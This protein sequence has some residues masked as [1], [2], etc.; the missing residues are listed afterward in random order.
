MAWSGSPMAQMLPSGGAICLT[1]RTCCAST[2]WYSSI[3]THRQRCRYRARSSGMASSV[4]AARITRSSKSH[5]LR[6]SIALSYASS[7]AATSLGGLVSSRGASSRDAPRNRIAPRRV[8]PQRIVPST[9]RSVAHRSA[10]IVPQR[11]V[12]REMADSRLRARR[13]EMPSASRR[14]WT[15]S[16]SDATRKP[17]CK[18]AALWC[19]RR[20]DRPR[21]WNVC[22]GTRSQ[23]SGS[24][25]RRRS[26]ISPAA[27]RVKVI[28]RQ[29]AGGTAWSETRWAMRRVRVRVFPD[30]GPA[31]TSS[32]PVTV[33]A[34]R[35]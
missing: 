14:S 3:D 23:A 25:A 22:R 16:A 5:R 11:A 24:S 34:A 20:M 7:A 4:S 15:R 33:S 12:A 1:S 32:G 2:S 6:A 26:R 35:R 21:E 8:V 27:R 31:T 10:R 18:P 13:S 29:Q 9:R 28:A 19:S 30:P 17:R